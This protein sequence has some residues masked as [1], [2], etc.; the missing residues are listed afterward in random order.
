MG[1]PAGVKRDFEALEDRRREAARLLRAGWNQAD[2]AR[3]VGVHRQ[4]VSRWAAALEE[5]GLRSLRKAGRAGRKPRLSSLDIERIRRKLE[6]GAEAFGYPSGLWTLQ[7]VGELI[8]RECG[9]SFHVSQVWRILRAMGWSPQRPVGR[10]VERDEEAIEHWK[11]VEW[12]RLKKTPLAKDKSSSSSTRVDSASGPTDAA[13]GRRAAKHR[14]SS[15][16]S[17]GRRSR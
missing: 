11:R 12:P 7:R 4:S 16:T 9:V 8:E 5:G 17:T 10:A 2:V 6:K 3:E 1:N 13:L 15:T 14:S